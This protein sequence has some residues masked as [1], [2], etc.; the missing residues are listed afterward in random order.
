MEEELISF[1]NFENEK[2]LNI[3]LFGSRV[4]KIHKETSDYDY[5]FIVTDDYIYKRP[6]N[7]QV[8][9]EY[10][11]FTFTNHKEAFR[12]MIKYKDI[13]IGIYKE[14]LFRRLLE[15]HLIWALFCIHLPKEFIFKETVKF[16][17]RI[18][19]IKL[20]NSVLMEVGRT[21]QKA[22]NLFVKEKAFE[23]GRKL[24]FY[25]FLYLYWGIHFKEEKGFSFEEAVK[26][27]KEIDITESNDWK[28]FVV[29]FENEYENLKEYFTENMSHKTLKLSEKYDLNMNRRELLDLIKKLKVDGLYKEFS[30]ESKVHEKYDNIITFNNNRIESPIH[31]SCI[32][33]CNDLLVDI[34]NEY[35]Y[36][37][38]KGVLKPTK[39]REKKDSYEV[40]MIYYDDQWILEPL[41]ITIEKEFWSIWKIEEYRLP[42]EKYRN[43]VFVFEINSSK[44]KRILPNNDKDEIFLSQVFERK[45]Y[46]VP[47]DEIE[48]SKE[49]KYKINDWKDYKIDI[50][51]NLDDFCD[52]QYL[53]ILLKDD[54]NNQE[55]ILCPL[56]VHLKS[57]IDY[58]YDNRDFIITPNQKLSELLW[59]CIK[60]SSQENQFVLLNI[61]KEY[62]IEVLIKVYEDITSSFNLE[63][64]RL[65]N[66]YNKIKE[67]NNKDFSQEIHKEQRKMILYEMRNK[68][69]EIM[70]SIRNSNFN[71]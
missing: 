9:Y 5:I 71:I 26:I 6:K 53:G 48:F 62:K 34:K 31:Y 19:H 42:S 15:E 40:I 54:E 7:E 27:K 47:K 17:P 45:D 13:N 55:K 51:Q 63:I 68:G 60:F 3:Y 61:L 32:S 52:Y 50:S 64:E 4:Y 16:Q 35:F 59:L 58:L 37:S 18:R 30:I 49:L 23:K 20:R 21:W 2:I 14:T 46:L 39:Y 33:L 28:V 10:E 56:Y 43:F 12:G 70:K 8:S 44:S 29:K 24:I 57:L 11:Q 38:K 41:N 22:K 36:V 69:K 25:T 65:L 67:K 1:L 66:L